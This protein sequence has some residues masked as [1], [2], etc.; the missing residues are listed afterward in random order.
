MFAPVNGRGANVRPVA[1]R[2]AVSMCATMLAAAASLPTP[3][4]GA[5]GL[6]VAR[7]AK[8]VQLQENAQLKFIREDGSALVE[9]GQAAGTYNAPVSAIMTIHSTSVTSVVTLFPKGGS[10]T[11][12]AQA[13]YIVKGSIGYFGGTFT[14]TH[15]TGTYR[16]ASGKALGISGTINRET[17][18]MTVKAHGEISL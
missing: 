7:A 6:A 15:G 8:K 3:A 9:H 13:N 2:L 4:S 11:G 5:P 17:F 10:I 12:T 16:H 18:A 1:I 14:I